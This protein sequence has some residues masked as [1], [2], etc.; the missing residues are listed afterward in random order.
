MMKRAIQ[1]YL[2][3]HDENGRLNQLIRQY[4]LMSETELI[5]VLME[6]S[7]EEGLSDVQALEMIRKVRKVK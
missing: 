2:D 6:H 4:P 7:K 5:Q 3:Q 1:L